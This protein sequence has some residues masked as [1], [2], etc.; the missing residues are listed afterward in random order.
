MTHIFPGDLTNQCG[1]GL[2]LTICLSI[3]S[4]WVVLLV[5]S[6]KSDTEIT[7]NNE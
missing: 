7:I 2:S 4:V 1:N 5:G 6:M 3:I